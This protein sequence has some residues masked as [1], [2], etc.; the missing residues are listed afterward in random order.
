MAD[1][2]Y[3]VL[4]VAKDAP[5]N[6][7]RKAYR[8]IFAHEGTMAERLDDVAEEFRENEPVMEIVDFIRFGD[9][10]FHYE[11][12][13]AQRYAG[14]DIFGDGNLPGHAK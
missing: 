1:D 5:Q 10:L 14:R 9:A 8:L 7:I 6:D 13:A 2:P 4:G 12:S 3:R 11:N